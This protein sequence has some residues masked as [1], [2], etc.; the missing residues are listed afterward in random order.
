VRLVI[1]SAICLFV[2]QGCAGVV[3]ADPSGL[4]APPGGSSIPHDDRP[5]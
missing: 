5:D 2:L 3:D 4:N 1:L